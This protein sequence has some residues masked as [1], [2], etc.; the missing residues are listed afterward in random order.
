M[1]EQRKVVYRR[2]QQILDG[3]DL[4]RR[5]SPTSRRSSSGQVGVFC[6]PTTPRT[7]TSTVCSTTSPPFPTGFT[8]DELAS[9]HGKSQIRESLL[10]EAL[11]YYEQREESSAPTPCARSSAGDALDPRPALARAPLRDGLPQEGINLRAMA[12]RIPSR[13]GSGRVTTCLGRMSTA[14]SDDFVRY[15]M[16]LDVVVENAPQPE[17]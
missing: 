12:R 5:P 6:P 2:R 1:N 15:V 7:G 8:A 14:I 16:H 9:A 17:S 11:R 10:A 13:S 3:A 4:R